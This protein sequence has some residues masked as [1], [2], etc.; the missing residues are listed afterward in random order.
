MNGEKWS[1]EIH[2]ESI[3]YWKLETHVYV[4][5]WE[6]ERERLHSIILLL[7]SRLCQEVR[8]AS[9]YMLHELKSH[10]LTYADMW[11]SSI[12]ACF[13]MCQGRFADFWQDLRQTLWRHFRFIARTEFTV[14]QSLDF[15][16]ALI[17]PRFVTLR[18]ITHALINPC[19]C[20]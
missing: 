2:V 12:Q 19:A 3:Q 10:V 13:L 14:S 7:M 9:Q 1:V 20:C 18:K 11:Q 6:R 15:S 5:V 4:F 17:L 16:H 8:T